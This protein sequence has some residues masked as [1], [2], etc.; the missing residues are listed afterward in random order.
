MRTLGRGLLTVGKALL[1]QGA[2]IGFWL[3]LGLVLSLVFGVTGRLDRWVRA[4]NISPSLLVAIA[5]FLTVCVQQGARQQ[6]AQQMQRPPD[7]GSPGPPYRAGG[8]AR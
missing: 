3:A 1:A 7:E 2:V 4:H 6:N 5:V 8:P